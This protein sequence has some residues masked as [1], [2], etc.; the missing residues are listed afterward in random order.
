[1]R[2]LPAVSPTLAQQVWEGMSNPSTRRVAQ[3]IRGNHSLRKQNPHQRASY[4]LGRKM[5]NDF[6]MLVTQWL[7]SRRGEPT[8][9]HRR[10]IAANLT[11]L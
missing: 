3:K 11:I 10:R 5:L 9:D 7:N 1:M 8:S 2:Q 4:G 6:G